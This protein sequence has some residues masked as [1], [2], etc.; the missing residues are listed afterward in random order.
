MRAR[1]FASVILAVATS[2][3]FQFSAARAEAREVKFKELAFLLREGDRIRVVGAKGHVR[4]I[5]ASRP[6]ADATA[7]EN[8]TAPNALLRVRK[9]LDDKA[10]SRAKE[11]FDQ[12]TYSLRKEDNVTY[13]EA[14]GSDAKSDWEAQLKDGFPEF[15]FEIEAPPVAAEI[16]LREG[17]FETQ[18]WKAAVAV[19]IVEGQVRMAKNEGPLRVQVQR[20]EV[21]IDGHKGRVD[22]DGFNPKTHLTE[23][24]GDLNLDNFAGDSVLQGLR[25]SLRMTAFS[26]QTTAS[27]V[28]GGCD[29]TVGR[30]FL[31]LQGLEGGLRGQLGN[32]SVVAKL[33]GE[34]EVN[35]EA[36]EG[37][38]SLRLPPSSGASVRLQTEDG[39]LSA[40]AQL[41]S[42]HTATRKVV[43]GRLSGT[44]KGSV[45]VKTKTGNV[46]LN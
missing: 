17:R 42:S 12:W 6:L 26:G 34:P 32:G 45:F 31:N 15:V 21:R 30:G 40:P 10:S 1:S 16:N 37:S 33:L 36:K 38:V 25:G 5:A 8:K 13:I 4:L 43:A 19:Q 14:R 44:G 9:V 18:N 27:K 46:R 11:G 28:D 24:D 35:I 39:N 3:V 41:T 23:I 29:F 2:V 20:G 7:P 22:I